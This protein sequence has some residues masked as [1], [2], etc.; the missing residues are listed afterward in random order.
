MHLSKVEDAQ[1]TPRSPGLTKTLLNQ[2]DLEGI[3]RG[4]GTRTN[5]M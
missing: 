5:P 3:L 2:S 1:V 4:T